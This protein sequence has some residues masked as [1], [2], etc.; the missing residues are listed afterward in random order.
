LTHKKFTLFARW[1][2]KNLV[3]PQVQLRYILLPNQI[4]D[5]ADHL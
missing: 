5:L 1:V 2:I 4:N 3:G